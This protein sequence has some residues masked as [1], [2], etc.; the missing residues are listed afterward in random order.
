[1]STNIERIR[2]AAKEWERAYTRTEEIRCAIDYVYDYLEDLRNW[3]RLS[4][5][6][7]EEASE[8]I[9]SLLGAIVEEDEWE[10]AQQILRDSV[11]R[12]QAS[13]SPEDVIRID[14]LG[15]IRIEVE[16]EQGEEDV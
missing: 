2:D 1:M 6:R 13:V 8:T 10:Q 3:R 11:G 4:D 14:I 15:D 12:S 5:K 7:E 16:D 9:K